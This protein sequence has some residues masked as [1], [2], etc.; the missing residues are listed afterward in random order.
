IALAFLLG[1]GWLLSVVPLRNFDGGRVRGGAA[2][3]ESK[4]QVV[5]LGSRRF[6]RFEDAQE[7]VASYRS[8]G[9]EFGDASLGAPPN[10]A[11]ANVASWDEWIRAEDR[12][13][14]SRIERGA[15]DSISNLVLYGNS[16]TRLPRIENSDEAV[17]AVGG[18]SQRARERI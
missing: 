18:L 7:I 8:S 11:L 2:F 14:R 15:A 5:T 6:V 3:L 17:T 16:Y 1:P 13:I 10:G 9:I 12:E 4:A